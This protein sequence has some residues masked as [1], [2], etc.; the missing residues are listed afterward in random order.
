MTSALDADRLREALLSVQDGEVEE[1]IR[2]L[3]PMVS[4]RR[5]TRPS[6]RLAEP[7]EIAEITAWLT[8]AMADPT[9]EEAR[10]QVERAYYKLR[11]YRTG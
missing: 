1:A 11:R 2:Q 7:L 10:F 4:G 3:A 6:G 5:F 9:S 8:S